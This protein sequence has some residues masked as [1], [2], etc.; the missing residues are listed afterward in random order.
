MNKDLDISNQLKHLKISNLHTKKQ[1][2][3]KQYQMYRYE[4]PFVVSRDLKAESS[5]EQ[6][7]GIGNEQNPNT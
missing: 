1:L 2:S 4:D 5:D 6:G 3:K 7:F